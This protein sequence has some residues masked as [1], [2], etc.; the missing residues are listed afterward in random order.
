MRQQ[1]HS[2]RFWKRPS[3][4]Y[5]KK[6]TSSSWASSEASRRVMLANRRRDTSPELAVRRRLHAAGLRYRVDYAPLG[7]RSRADVVFTRIHVVVFIDGCF[8]HACPEHAT[9]PKRN[10][11]YWLPKLRRNVQRDC[12]T[13]DRLRDAGWTVLRFWEH[14]DPDFVANTVRAVVIYE[15]TLWPKRQDVPRFLYSQAEQRTK[16]DCCSLS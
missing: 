14:E 10:S 11:D 15:Q 13:N 1:R 4:R 12:E 16:R 5:S 9:S 8:W 7:G 3:G 6:M 2:R